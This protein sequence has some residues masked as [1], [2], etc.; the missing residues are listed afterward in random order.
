MQQAMRTDTMKSCGFIKLHRELWDHP[1]WL[2]STAEQKVVLVTL[3]GMANH[4]PNKWE[5]NGRIY[6]V[7]RGQMI[8]SLKSISDACGKGVS[9]QN[10]RTA[11]DRFERLG[12]LTNESTKT[13]RLITIV[14]YSK[15]QDYKSQSN[16]DDD[17][18]LTKDQHNPNKDLTS[19]K[20]EKH[21]KHDKNKIPPSFEDVQA[22]CTERNNGI[23]PRAFIDFYNAK[24]WMIGKNKMKDWKASV[25]TWERTNETT[26]NTTKPQKGTG[27]VG[28]GFEGYEDWFN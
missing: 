9:T 19:N 8:T 28:D 22:Y 12:F 23:D 5:W 20:N 7:E 6:Q 3:I 4:K 11:L 1:I 15:W 18:G 2:K 25:R 16:K 24:G 14:N 21:E 17:K 26:G 27:T 13:G 10:V